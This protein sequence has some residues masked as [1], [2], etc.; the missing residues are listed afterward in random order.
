[1]PF[2]A[3]RPSYLSRHL[4]NMKNDIHID[5]TTLWELWYG[6]KGVHK[7]SQISRRPF[8]LES[9]IV[10]PKDVNCMANITLEIIPYTFFNISVMKSLNFSEMIQRVIGCKKQVF[11]PRWK[12]I[13][14][15]ASTVRCWKKFQWSSFLQTTTLQNSK[16]ESRAGTD[17]NMFE[18]YF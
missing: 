16:L 10:L 18:F 13:L 2:Y 3:K 6:P 12:Y 17:K 8:S 5:R 1:M 15:K 4:K 7:V 14:D 11:R 9:Q